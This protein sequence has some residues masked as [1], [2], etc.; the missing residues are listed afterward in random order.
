MFPGEGKEIAQHLADSCYAVKCFVESLVHPKKFERMKILLLI[1]CSN[2][3]AD[4][5]TSEWICQIQR[6][7]RTQ[8]RTARVWVLLT[9]LLF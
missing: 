4:G 5:R 1:I 3:G 6:A 8:H 9:V 2:T 7:G